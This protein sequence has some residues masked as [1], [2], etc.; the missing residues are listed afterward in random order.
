MIGGGAGASAQHADDQPDRAL[1][2]LGAAPTGSGGIVL[3]TAPPPTLVTPV[4]G[5][6]TGTSLALGG[7]T[8]GG[9]TLAV[10]AGTCPGTPSMAIGNSTTGFCSVSTTGILNCALKPRHNGVP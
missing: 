5:A 8:L 7:A 1:T 2:A 4:L 10:P 9:S 6:A 3:A